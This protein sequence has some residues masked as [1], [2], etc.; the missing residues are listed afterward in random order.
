MLALHYP[1]SSSSSSYTNYIL[2][3]Y[4]CLA[5]KFESMFLLLIVVVNIHWGTLLHGVLLVCYFSVALV[6][7]VVLYVVKSANF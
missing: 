1:S 7:F 6:V 2:N 5:Y 4:V 3:V